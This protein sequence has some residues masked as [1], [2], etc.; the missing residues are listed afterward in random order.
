VNTL[1]QFHIY[2]ET[3]NYTEIYDKNGI[4]IKAKLD[5]IIS[6]DVYQ[7]HQSETPCNDAMLNPF[8]NY[9]PV[10]GNHH[11]KATGEITLQVALQD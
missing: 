5:T 6:S 8:S 9:L 1:E 4:P 7:C 11:H 2:S 3:R 10:N